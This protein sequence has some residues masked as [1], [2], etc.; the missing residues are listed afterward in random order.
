ML[1]P[2]GL[3]SCFYLANPEP[4]G[5]AAPV[6]SPSH[7]TSLLGTRN[8]LQSKHQGH[9]RLGWGEGIILLRH[10]AHN[11]TDSGGSARVAACCF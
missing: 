3:L 2:R 7:P 6:L 11:K 8:T 10:E 1:T 5:A 9:A 4:S